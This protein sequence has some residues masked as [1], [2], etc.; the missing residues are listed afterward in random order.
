L[1]EQPTLARLTLTK[2]FRR[3]ECYLGPGNILEIGAGQYNTHCE[4]LSDDCRHFSLNIAISEK[5]AIAGDACL[6]PFRECSFD[7][8]IMLEVLEHIPT[9]ELLIT[10]IRR[11]LKTGGMMIGST[12][13]IHPQHGAPNDY[14]RFTDTSLG[15]LFS[16]FSE[17]RIEKL[18]NRLHVLS[19]IFTENYQFLRIINRLLQ[20]IQIK[21][22]TCYSGLLF[23]VKK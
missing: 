17:C 20:Y 13:F 10:E 22:A 21:S 7:G 16:V 6:M 18:G 12:R 19:D 4:Y 11:V 23:I 8:I 15:L 9:P 3:A 14:Y 5:P 1:S 2:S